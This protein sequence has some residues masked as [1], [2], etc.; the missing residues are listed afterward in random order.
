MKTTQAIN[1]TEGTE[2]ITK[3]NRDFMPGLGKRKWGSQFRKDHKGSIDSS[4]EPFAVSVPP[5]RALLIFNGESV[6]VSCSWLDRAL[7]N[8]FWTIC[9]G[10]SHLANPMP[11]EEY[12][13][14]KIQ[15]LLIV[16][17]LLVFVFQFLY[18]S[19]TTLSR[20]LVLVF[21]SGFIQKK[22]TSGE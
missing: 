6:C 15:V 5:Q 19:S 7:G 14:Y 16:I 9:P 4:S 18:Q 8:I 17:L 3:N 1:L 2:R 13:R 21:Y 12:S 20:I 11:N 10:R 22:I